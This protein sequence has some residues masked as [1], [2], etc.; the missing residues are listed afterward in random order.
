MQAAGFTSIRSRDVSYVLMEMM[1]RIQRRL[2]RL[3]DLVEPDRLGEVAGLR[4]AGPRL[5]AAREFVRS[6]GVGY[7]LFTARNPRDM[8]S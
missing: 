8:A 2:D 6:G 5:A 7:A 3:D 4:N 1:K